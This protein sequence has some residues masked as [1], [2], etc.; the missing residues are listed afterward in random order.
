MTTDLCE[1]LSNA[2]A[3]T[4]SPGSASGVK[5][6]FALLTDRFPPHA[7][8]SRV[9]YYNLYQRLARQHS[10]SI[11]VLTTKVPGCTRFDSSEA[12]PGF[13]IIRRS[14]PFPDWKI[15]RIPRVVPLYFRALR[16]ARAFDVD[17]VHAGDLFPQGVVSMW[18]RKALG[19]PYLV[20]AHGEEIT[21]TDCFRH[22][23]R[24]R[25][26]VYRHADAVIAANDF[27][28]EQL[29]RIGVDAVRIH[30]IYPGVD[31]TRFSPRPPCPE[32]VRRLG[33]S[34]RRV[35]LSVGRL[36][37]HKGHSVLLHAMAALPERT[38]R[39]RYLIAGEGPEKERLMAQ[40]RALGIE[41]DVIFLGKV[42]EEDLPSLYNLCDFFALANLEHRGCVD[43]FGMVFLEANASG[44][45]VLAG[46]S[47]GTAGAVLEYKTG[48][49]F[50]PA[51]PSEVSAALKLMLSNPELRERM[52]REGRDRAASTF[53]WE[54]GA[55][56]LNEIC[57]RVLAER[58]ATKSR[59]KR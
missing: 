24:V 8:G 33:L 6:T 48:L 28:R 1:A 54:K 34:G 18:I 21:Q 15:Q 32:Q 58:S 44:K 52:G 3:E 39:P 31:S 10:R 7:G 57:T 49:L 13:R 36:V 20:Y 47:G 59:R 23:P 37:P 26:E 46:R 27:A 55:R 38:P 12:S 43:G 14:S 41:E 11:V 22:Q 53:C 29:L 4:R 50:N 30:T 45:P 5:R 25:N 56:Q 51:D 42:S 2:P 35:I 19:I 17:F 9:Y 16:M 40:A